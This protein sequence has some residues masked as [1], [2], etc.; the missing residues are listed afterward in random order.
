MFVF[1]H[2]KC[3]SLPKDILICH[4]DLVIHFWFPLSVMERKRKTIG[5]KKDKK[6]K[7]KGIKDASAVASGTSGTGIEDAS[8]VASG[9]SGTDVNTNDEKGSCTEG[10]TTNDKEN[11]NGQ[12]GNIFEFEMLS[13][14]TQSQSQSSLPDCGSHILLEQSAAASSFNRSNVSFSP[15][16]N[17]ADLHK[18]LQEARKLKSI[19]E[20]AKLSHQNLVDEMQLCKHQIPAAVLQR[21][22]AIGKALNG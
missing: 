21:I 8:A 10:D 13:P 22:E 1:V 18:C 6:K 9:K 20:S 3:F 7:Q 4:Y 12:N 16:S 19:V 2:C 11:L 17:P 15:G 14:L 5:N